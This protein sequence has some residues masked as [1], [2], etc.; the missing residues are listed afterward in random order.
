MRLRT[1]SGSA[2]TRKARF[3]MHMNGLLLRASCVP[4][5]PDCVDTQSSDV[6]AE[7][8]TLLA[9]AVVIVMVIVFSLNSR[10]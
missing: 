3:T 7:V 2:R 9:V 1:A 5:A 8:F 10:R 4:G 6:F